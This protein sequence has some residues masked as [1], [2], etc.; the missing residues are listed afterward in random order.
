MRTLF[1]IPLS[2]VVYYHIGGVAR[3]LIEISNKEELLDA[4]RQS[5][6]DKTQPIRIV[7]LGANVLIPDSGLDGVTLLLQPGNADFEITDDAH[8]SAFAGAT[9]DSLIKYAFSQNLSGFGWAGG[10]PSSVGGAVRG[11]AGCFGSEIK[12]YLVSVDVVDITDPELRVQTFSQKD[13]QFGYRDSIF[14]QNK[15]LIIISAVFQLENASFEQLAKD[16]A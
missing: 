6:K 13:C 12:D 16:E 3:L 9:M 11:N 15:Y 4:L 10:L 8:I 7:G 14:K 2:D 1:H 5:V